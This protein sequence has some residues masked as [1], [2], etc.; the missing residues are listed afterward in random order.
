MKRAKFHDIANWFSL[1][2]YN[3]ILDLSV[4]H[5]IAETF[6][7]NAR[8]SSLEYRKE[9]SFT[10]M[11]FPLIGDIDLFNEDIGENELSFDER[12]IMP[13]PFFIICAFVN[14][15]LDDGRIIIGETGRLEPR[16]EIANHDI[17]NQPMLYD[18][19]DPKS[20]GVTGIF[21]DIGL[22]LMN[23]EEMIAG[24]KILLRKWREQAGIPE[25]STDERR[26]FGLSTI[27]KIHQY[28]VIPYLDIARWARI[29]EMAVSNEL[30][31]RLLFPNPLS[32]GEVKGG[33]H[34][35]DTVKPFAESASDLLNRAALKK[36][37]A[38]NP[39]IENMRFSDFLKLADFQ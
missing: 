33:A 10:V 30:Y 24:F 37:Y 38:D 31:A 34:I 25:R 6:M 19:D 22:D 9:E 29:N 2:T 3:Y 13:L 15:C 17:Y 28:K 26:R 12:G 27:A 11:P 8:C 32:N 23:D 16:A 1:D 35:R 7:M 21:V 4:R 36:Y 14:S 5:V 39:H 20:D 18:I